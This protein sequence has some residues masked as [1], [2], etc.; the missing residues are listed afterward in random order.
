LSARTRPLEIAGIGA[1]GLAAG[2]VL[3]PGRS[4]RAGGALLVAGYVVVAISFY[5]VGDR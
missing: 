5:L 1:A 3:A 2:L 4:S